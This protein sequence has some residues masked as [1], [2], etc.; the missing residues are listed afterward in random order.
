MPKNQKSG[1]FFENIFVKREGAALPIN[2]PTNRLCEEK[3]ER[4][5]EVAPSLAR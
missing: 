5:F 4:A 1:H 3:K 2:Q